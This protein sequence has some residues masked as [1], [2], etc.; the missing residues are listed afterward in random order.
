MKT[1]TLSSIFLLAAATS[2]I[3]YSQ[4]ILAPKSRTLRPVSVHSTHG[5][6]L[7]PS[8]LTTHSSPPTTLTTFTDQSSTTYD[9]SI[10][11][12][13]LVS[14]D[15]ASVSSSPQAIGVTFSESALWISNASSDATADAGKD[16]TL[17]FNVTGPGRY[18]APRDKERGG[19]RYM[20]L[21]HDGLG[22]V[23]V[24]GVEVHYTPMPHWDDD[25]IGNYSGFFHCDGM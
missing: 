15:I 12:A 24:E 5:P 20:T 11:I 21:V 6:V 23:D 13:G 7:S 10:N 22:S 18:T 14:L 8:S 1:S 2:A 3:P 19:F 25:S 17:W 9:F 16:E 4:Y